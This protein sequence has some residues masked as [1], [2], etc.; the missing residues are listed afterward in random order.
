[1]FVNGTGIAEPILQTDSTS[2]RVLLNKVG[3][4]KYLFTGDEKALCDCNTPEEFE[5]AIQTIK[6]LT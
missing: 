1:M 4:S 3:Y 5:K 2:I 6:S